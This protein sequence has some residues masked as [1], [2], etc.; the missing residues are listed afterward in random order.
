M[1]IFHGAYDLEAFYDWD[2]G[3]FQGG[4]LVF[5]QAVAY[6]F[7]LTAG[8][9]FVVAH[10]RA[11][12]R[13][14]TWKR[15][16]RRS[17]QVLAAAALVSAATYLLDPETYVRFGILHLIGVGIALLPLFARLREANLAL[18]VAVIA[19]GKWVHSYAVTSSWLLP[20]GF[21]PPHFRS[22]DY[23]P[24]FPWFGAMLIG[25]GI[26]SLIYVR[27]ERTPNPAHSLPLWLSWPGRH[28]LLLYLAHQPVILLV[29]W[30]MVGRP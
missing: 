13:G 18:G 20:L 9:S 24:L 12:V 29:L 23:F 25:A 5:E 22:V 10:E 2:I 16:L 28:S 6:A 14:G 27:L 15:H 19:M 3:V 1:V 17:V 4:W 26:G 7:L 30:L 8:A 11:K 21:M